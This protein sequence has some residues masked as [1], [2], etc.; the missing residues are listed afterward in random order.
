MKTKYRIIKVEGFYNPYYTVEKKLW[1]FPAWK[2]IGSDVTYN[3][4]ARIIEKSQYK[5]SKEIVK[6]FKCK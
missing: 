4:A 2:R 5:E 6:V 1:W 3:G